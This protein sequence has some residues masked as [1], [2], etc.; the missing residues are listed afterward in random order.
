M[1]YICTNYLTASITDITVNPDHYMNKRLFVFLFAAAFSV[2]GLKAQRHEL[3]VRFGMSNLV[4]DIGRTNYLL[5]GPIGP[6]SEM[7]FPGY[8]GILYRMNFNP[9][10]TLRFDLGYSHIQFDDRVA[11]EEYRRNR[12]M[13]GTNNL[14]EASAVFEYYFFPVNNEQR[15]GMLSPY[16]FLGVGAMM[17]DV[18]QANMHHDFK[19][20]ANGVAIAPANELDFNSTVTYESGRKITGFVPAG[21]GLK[22]KFNYNWAIS[23]EVMIRPTLADQLDYS[24][25]SE[26][27]IKSTYNSEILAPGTSQSLLQTGI[28]YSVSKDREAEFYQNRKV[29]DIKSTDWVNSVTLG[30]TYSFG[31]PPCYCE[32]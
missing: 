19:R 11:K 1:F 28:Y 8:G 14:L 4:G 25:I 30:L 17:H 12:Q 31:R 21:I 15:R 32:D 9:Y 23:G 6:M 18:T 10:Q 13:W 3:G 24:E 26:K 29:G 5:Q 7:G 16:V 2:S 22:Y 20:D 27:D